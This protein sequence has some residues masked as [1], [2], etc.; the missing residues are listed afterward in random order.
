MAKTE[1]IIRLLNSSDNI[2]TLVL[3]HKTTFSNVLSGQIGVNFLR[4]Y[5]SLILEKGFI[6]GYFVDN[7]LLAF[8][9]GA[10]NE[11]VISSPKFIRQTIFGVLSHIS[12]K[13][14][15]NLFRY[16]RKSF[17]LND[18]TIK[19]ELLSI[20]VSD[21]LR[22]QGI[23][24]QLVHSFEE[25]MILNSIQ[26]YKVYTDLKFSTGSAFYEKEGF[27]LCKEMNLFGL[28]TKLFIKKLNSNQLHHG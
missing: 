20:I 19:A 23:G 25:Y 15:L 22:G 5:Y 1:G 17:L 4:Y 12:F 9:S 28:K 10:F 7:E 3:M 18:I 14:I 13:V 11:K 16:V 2:D 24:K 21:Q 26:E 6:F 27:K 8:V